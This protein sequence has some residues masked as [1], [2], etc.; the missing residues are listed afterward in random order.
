MRDET[1]LTEDRS[2]NLEA[3][4]ESSALDIDQKYVFV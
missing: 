3:K 1:C 4:S 2:E